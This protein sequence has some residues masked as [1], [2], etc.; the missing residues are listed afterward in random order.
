MTVI[1]VSIFIGLGL[2]LALLIFLFVILYRE[3]V[4]T[5][6]LQTQYNEA[7]KQSIGKIK[8]V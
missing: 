5:Q 1:D 8:R 3:S 6:K 2:G 7:L 4:K